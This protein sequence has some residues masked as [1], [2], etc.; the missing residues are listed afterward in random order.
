MLKQAWLMFAQLNS[1]VA[2]EV[3]WVEDLFAPSSDKGAKR[4]ASGGAS[5]SS[6]GAKAPK[7][8]D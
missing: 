3:C 5:S 6:K 4:A 7:T 2:S 8:G 1:L